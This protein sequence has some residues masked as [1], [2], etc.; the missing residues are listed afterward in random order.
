MGRHCCFDGKL[1]E[2]RFDAAGNEIEIRLVRRRFESGED[3]LS[4][5]NGDWVYGIEAYDLT[6]G[7]S[8]AAPDL[9]FDAGIAER[10]ALMCVRNAVTPVTL[11]DV[12][13]DWLE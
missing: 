12:A 13:E 9:T 5:R 2:W 11:G 10:F 8:A 7:E 1:K 4:G 6:S 3:E